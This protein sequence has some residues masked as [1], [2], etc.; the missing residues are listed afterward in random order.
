MV[1]IDFKNRAIIELIFYKEYKI[2]IY[3][4]IDKEI[5]VKL[6]YFYPL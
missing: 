2:I 5:N 1:V 3:V 6:N 4:C